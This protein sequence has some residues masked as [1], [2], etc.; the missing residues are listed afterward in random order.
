MVRIQP[1]ARRERRVPLARQEAKATT[2]AEIGS[3]PGNSIPEPSYAWHTL[4]AFVPGSG[5]LERGVPCQDRAAA[6]DSPRPALAVLDGRGSSALSHEGAEAALTALREEIE[7]LENRLRAALDEDDDDGLAALSWQGL[8]QWLYTVAARVQRELASV[9]DRAASDYE[10]TLSLAIGGIRRTVWMAVGDSPLVACRSGILFLPCRLEAPEF[11][12][13]TSF[14]QAS[15]GHS[16]RL[17]GGLI[18][19]EGLDLIAA[20]SDGTASRL[21]DLQTQIA[22]EAVR[23]LAALL[24]RGEI[25]E[26]LLGSLLEEDAWS[27]VTRDDR[28]L[29]M[30]ARNERGTTVIEPDDSYASP[31]APPFVATTRDEPPVPVSSPAPDESPGTPPDLPRWI[32]VAAFAILTGLTATLFAAPVV[33]LLAGIASSR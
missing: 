19:S 20:M 8:A 10:F 33:R 4:S 24:T 1:S 29:A 12:N 17:R 28:C 22:S 7:S 3:P 30:L 9:S 21:I 2:A 14:V 16:P 15:P 25:D 31:I 23:N 26:A 27:E 32:T 11:A 6:W 13:Q 18:P 5:H